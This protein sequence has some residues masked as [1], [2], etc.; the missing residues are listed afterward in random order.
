MKIIYFHSFFPLSLLAPE[1]NAIL[2]GISPLQA[3]GRTELLLPGSR[4]ICV[5]WY[6]PHKVSAAICL[7]TRLHLY[8]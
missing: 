1:N 4:K 8:H 5:A 2:Q 6:L 7:R 3:T